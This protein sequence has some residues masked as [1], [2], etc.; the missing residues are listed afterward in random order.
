MLVKGIGGICL[1]SGRGSGGRVPGPPVTLGIPLLL[2]RLDGSVLI[3]GL[4]AWEVGP[5]VINHP[6]PGWQGAGGG[7]GLPAEP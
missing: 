2:G 4:R 5:C 3:A 6:Q 7:L 1:Q